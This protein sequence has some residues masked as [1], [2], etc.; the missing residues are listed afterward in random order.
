MPSSTERAAE[1]WA[2]ALRDTG[3]LIAFRARTVRRRGAAATGAL[4]VLALTLGFAWMPAALDARGQVGDILDTLVESL[5]GN[6][7]A[8]LLGI[9]FLS[10]ASSMGSGGGREL[11]SRSEA[12]IHPVSAR[13]EHLGALALA[14]LNLAWLI[15]LWALMAV[16]ALVTPPGRLAGAQVVVVTWILAASALGQAI[17][18]AVEGVRRTPHGVVTVRAGGA[19]VALAVGALHLTGTLTSGGRGPADDPARGDHA[20]RPLVRRR[21]RPAAGRRP[22]RRA[23][24]PARRCGRSGC[25][26]ARS[27]AC[28]PVCTRPAT[29]PSLGGARP[30]EHCCAGS[31]ATRS[32]ARSACGAA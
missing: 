19:L 6:V 32:G 5:R 26:R 3:Y 16:V 9:L 18:W 8:A 14:P 2:D 17:G 30:T 4:V 15:Q 12:A 7:G 11:L 20:G 25:R 21:P 29:L 1:G 31:T 23:R 13:T 10:I 28:S 24:R 27:S 22:R